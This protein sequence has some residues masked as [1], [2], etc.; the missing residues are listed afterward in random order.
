MQYQLNDRIGQQS[1]HWSAREA[2]DRMNGQTCSVTVRVG[3][4]GRIVATY[5]RAEF[6]AL[7]AT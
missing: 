5:T 1:Y 7:Y 3:S 2:I 4:A 6:L